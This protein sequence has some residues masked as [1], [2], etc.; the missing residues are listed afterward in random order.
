[1]KIHWILIIALA[2]VVVVLGMLL[3]GERID[4]EAERAVIRAGIT[5][6]VNAANAKDV[7][8]MVAGFADDAWLLPPNAPLASG[9]EAIRTV[10]TELAERPGLSQ[11]TEAT[12]VEVSSTADLGYAVGTYESAW[13]DAEGNP[14]TDRGKWIAV[15][16]KQPDGTWGCVLDIWNSDQPAPGPAS[17]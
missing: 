17:E 4:V 3:M 6:W 12:K 16:K 14:V 11:S 8:G 5:E 7:E 10:W 9:K 15:Y 13:N 2:V 1:M